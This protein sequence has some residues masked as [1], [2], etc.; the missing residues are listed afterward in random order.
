LKYFLSILF[1]DLNCSSFKLLSN[2]NKTKNMSLC[3]V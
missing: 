2:D 3:C 1:K